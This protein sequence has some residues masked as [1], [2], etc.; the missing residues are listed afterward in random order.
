MVA[1]PDILA[2][3]SL[4]GPCRARHGR[5]AALAVV[6]A[7]LRQLRRANRPKRLADQLGGSPPDSPVRVE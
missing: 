4:G 6:P 1:H 5:F 3:Q 2:E 7:V